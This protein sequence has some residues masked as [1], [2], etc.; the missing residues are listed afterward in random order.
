MLIWMDN[1]RALIATLIMI[2][3]SVV[4][5]VGVKTVPLI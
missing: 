3:I 4:L 2:D 1:V 5:L